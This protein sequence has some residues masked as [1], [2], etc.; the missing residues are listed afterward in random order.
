LSNSLSEINAELCSSEAMLKS[1][2][3]DIPAEL[4]NVSSVTNLIGKKE[5]EIKQLETAVEKARKEF[6][7]YNEQYII[8]KAALQKQIDTEIEMVKK[9]ES[10]KSTFSAE[11]Q[12]NG[13][14]DL[15]HFIAVLNRK[16]AL[17]DNKQKLQN[18]YIKLHTAEERFQRAKDKCEG[19]AAADISLIENVCKDLQ[20]KVDSLTNQIASLR[21]KHEYLYNKKES[22]IKLFSIL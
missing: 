1:I 13:L 8:S 7:F 18:F 20:A 19:Y 22:V 4:Q 3:S 16:A 6:E 14:T 11:I 2:E 12:E 15:D 5:D 9:V 21:Q 10:V 17:Q